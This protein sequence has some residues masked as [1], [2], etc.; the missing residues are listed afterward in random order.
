[1]WIAYSLFAVLGLFFLY[2][3][4]DDIVYRRKFD[5][6]QSR[7]DVPIENYVHL[8]VVEKEKPTRFKKEKRR[9]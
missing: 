7:P 8:R 1:M 3:F 5:K 6:R 2:L 4:V 9:I